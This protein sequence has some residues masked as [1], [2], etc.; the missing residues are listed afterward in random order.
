METKQLPEV[1]MFQGY[2]TL[3]VDEEPYVILGGEVHNSAASGEAYMEEEVWPNV[4]DLG[5]NTV[6]APVYW[7]CIEPKPGA[8]DFSTVDDLLRQARRE[9]LRLVLLWFGLW[10]NAESMY[11]PT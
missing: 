2:Q 9:N 11:V 5:M 6:V 1:K 10:K 8:F 7:E 4:R 3:F